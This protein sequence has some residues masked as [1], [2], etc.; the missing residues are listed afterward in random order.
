MNELKVLANIIQSSIGRI[1]TAVS[2]N[3]LA[4]PSPDST[5]SLEPWLL[6]IHPGIR[7]AG[8]LVTSVAAQ[9]IKL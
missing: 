2:A 6:C 5:L 9:L 1:E 3:A 8:S 4:F 7:S